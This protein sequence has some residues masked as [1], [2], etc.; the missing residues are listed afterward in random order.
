[1]SDELE[2][3]LIEYCH[4][5]KE[6]MDLVIRCAIKQKKCINKDEFIE[7]LYKLIIKNK[8]DVYVFDGNKYNKVALPNAEIKKLILLKDPA[9][10]FLYSVD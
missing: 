7:A 8:M 9:E 5:D 1:M 6:S 3:Y 4:Y 2:D 10:V